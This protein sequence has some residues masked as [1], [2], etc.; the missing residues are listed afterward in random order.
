MLKTESATRKYDRT[1][2][3]GDTLI[4]ESLH[5]LKLATFT[6]KLLCF[7][8]T[9]LYRFLGKEAKQSIIS[10]GNHRYSR[11]AVGKGT[12]FASQLPH[13]TVG[14]AQLQKPGQDGL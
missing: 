8:K 14:T 7:H 4:Q 13:S 10:K 6:T 11:R 2:T 5:L 9:V 3:L 1:W 12:P